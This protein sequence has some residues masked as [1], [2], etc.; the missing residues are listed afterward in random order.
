M[1]RSAVETYKFASPNPEYYAAWR[2]CG[3]WVVVFTVTLV[4]LHFAQVLPL[5]EFLWWELFFLGFGL[6]WLALWT[7]PRKLGAGIQISPE[8]LVVDKWPSTNRV[9]IPWQDIRSIRLETWRERDLLSRAYAAVA[10]GKHASDPYVAIETTRMVSMPFW[11][12]RT[13]TRQ[14][15]IPRGKVFRIYLDDPQGF[16]QLARQFLSQTD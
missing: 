4:V 12:G 1:G 9:F 5:T 8:L 11:S 7:L 6:T 16:L 2:T 3:S 15:G 13:T 14:L 10:F